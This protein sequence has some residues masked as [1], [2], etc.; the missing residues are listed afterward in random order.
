MAIY[1][2]VIEQTARGQ[3]LQEAQRRTAGE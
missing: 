2:A 3:F 1:Q